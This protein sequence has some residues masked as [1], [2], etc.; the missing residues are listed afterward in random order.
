M[1][2]NIAITLQFITTSTQWS[3]LC[4][5][6]LLHFLNSVH[7]RLRLSTPFVIIFLV[8]YRRRE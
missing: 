5:A 3:N 8:L 1:Q 6:E 2:L 4:V 7:L